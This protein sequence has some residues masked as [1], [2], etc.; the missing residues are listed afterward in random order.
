MSLMILEA[1][2]YI[3]RYLSKPF[4]IYYSTC[5]LLQYLLVYRYFPNNSSFIFVSYCPTQGTNLISQS[6]C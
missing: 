2:Y 5:A 1:W 4:M 6:V 3:K